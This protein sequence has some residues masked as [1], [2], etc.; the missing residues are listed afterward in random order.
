MDDGSVRRAMMTMASVTPRNYLMLEVKQNLVEND[1][2]ENLKKFS[3]PHFK[4]TA[5]VVMG[6]PPA[7]FKKKV[8]EKILA[9][10]T[11]KETTLFKIAYV[12]VLCS[13][14]R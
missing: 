5:H 4:K 7:A 8:Q 1:R 6:D 11:E 12:V 10:K 14:F 3:L 9:D 2:K 13:V